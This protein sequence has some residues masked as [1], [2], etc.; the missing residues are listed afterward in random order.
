MRIS[1]W[2]LGVISAFAQTVYPDPLTN[3]AEPYC[4][5]PGLAIE[6]S[7]ALAAY[8][9]SATADTARYG[10]ASFIYWVASQGGMLIGTPYP[11]SV[12]LSGGPAIGRP[13]GQ[14]GL[15]AETAFKPGFKIGLGGKISRD[16]WT[17]YAE[18]TRLHATTNTFQTAPSPVIQ[19]GGLNLGVYLQE[20]F[21]VVNGTSTQ[22]GLKWTYHLDYGDIQLSRPSYLGTHLILEP[23]AGV[24]AALIIQ[25]GTGVMQGI[26]YPTFI[27]GNPAYTRLATHAVG[28]GPKIGANGSWHIKNGVRL[29]GNAYGA[30]L[31]TRYTTISQDV[32]NID[33]VTDLNAKPQSFL[34]RNVDTV[35][36]MAG[37][38]LGLGW[39][40]YWGK[41]LYFDVS[42]NYEFNVFWAQ[43]MLFSARTDLPLGDLYLQG[44]TASAR[45]DF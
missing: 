25:K 30:I 38:A 33:L 40:S 1:K 9:E 37:A 43:N 34:S 24:R 14:P 19:P 6:P 20:F 4:F 36:P 3:C 26:R 44:L 29:N 28:I 32:D 12:P 21:P 2:L 35:R 42:A 7:C 41:K 22:M 10:T 13:Q 15:F 45:C 39:G 17:V 23:F 5:Q 18:Y 11:S 8:N 16:N 27:S 31:F